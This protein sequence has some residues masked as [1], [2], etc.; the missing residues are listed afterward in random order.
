MTLENFKTKYY[1]KLANKLSSKKLN[2]ICYWSVL[3]SF[4]NGKKIPCI[5]PIIHSDNFITDFREKSEL[6][7]TFFAQ[8]CSLIENSRTLPTCIFLKIGKYLPTIH[9]YEEDILKIIRSLDPNKGHG[10][11]NIS[12]RMTNYVIKKSVN[13]NI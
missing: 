7:K 10:H 8:Q 1:F 3:K 4:A 11:D 13:L 2:Q 5:P 9:F 6:F 12:F